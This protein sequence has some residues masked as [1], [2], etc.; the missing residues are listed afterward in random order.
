MSGSLLDVGHGARERTVGGTALRGGA[1]SQ[2]TEASSGWVKRT[3]A[4]STSTTPS[5][6]AASSASTTLLP[7]AVHRREELYVGRPAVA[8]VSRTS[9]EGAESR[10]RRAP[11]SFVRLP[12]TGSGSPGSSFAPCR[13]SSRP[14]S[15]A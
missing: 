5:S 14:S 10:A 1:S 12:G 4:S 9:R 13:F 15:S 2:Q 6:A 11:R 7:V 3:R 8:A